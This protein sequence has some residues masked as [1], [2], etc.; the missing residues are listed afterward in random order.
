MSPHEVFTDFTIAT[1]LV[2]NGEYLEFINA[3]GYKNFNYWHAE[4]WDWVKTNH[5]EAPLYW[6]LIDGE[7][8]Q[9]HLEWIAES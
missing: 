9:L 5:I 4:G 8:H 1:N 6:H 7:W 2:T 3:G